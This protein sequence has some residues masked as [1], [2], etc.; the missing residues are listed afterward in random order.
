[1]DRFSKKKGL[2]SIGCR[3]L[4]KIVR[5]QPLPQSPAVSDAIRMLAKKIAKGKLE[6]KAE[7]AS[8]WAL[9]DHAD[10]D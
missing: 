10:K 6:K 7:V 8:I 5:G 2:D 1:M 9:A 4:S 3:A